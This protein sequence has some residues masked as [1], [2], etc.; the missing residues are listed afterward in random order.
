MGKRIIILLFLLA[1]AIYSH[2][3]E[4]TQIIKGTVIDSDTRSPLSG[5]NI[6]ELNTSPPNGAVTDESGRFRIT[7]RIGRITIKI[8]YLGYE[9][10]IV[11]DILVGSG[12]EIELEIALQE[13]VVQTSDVVVRADKSGSKNINQMATI[14]TNTIRTD[15]A[16]RYAGGFYDPSR[17][18]NAFAGIVP[19]LLNS[20][21][22]FQE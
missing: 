6:I 15:D 21:M 12:K 5:A 19:S 22:P 3:Q 16:L 18:V 11:Q 9:D 2:S 13:K 17:I 14:S 1:E 7:T 20:E 10:I 4:L 8:T